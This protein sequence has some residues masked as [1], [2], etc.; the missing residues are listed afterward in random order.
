MSKILLIGANGFIGKNLCQKLLNSNHRV[1]EI[2]R[3]T[4]FNNKPIGDFEKFNNWSE[5][6]ASID[7]VIHLVGFVHKKKLLK[8]LDKINNYDINFL[9][10]KKIASAA[11]LSNVKQFIFLSTV[12]IH[13]K[14]SN[15]KPINEDS[16]KLPYSEYTFTKL[17]AEESLIEIS[18]S[19]NLNYTIVRPQEI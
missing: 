17:L 13:G 5:L 6:L 3:N 12:G 10:T 1:E 4:I 15:G 19:K 2:S 11:S 14:N 16:D 7:V 18:K 8:K 9:L